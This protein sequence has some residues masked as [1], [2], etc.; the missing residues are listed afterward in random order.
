MTPNISQHSRSCQSA[1]GYTATHDSAS[2]ARLVDVDLQRE[3]HVARRGLHVREHLEAAVGAGGAVGD[4]L[5]LHRRRRVAAVLVALAGRGL[6]VD[7][8]DERQVVAARAR[9]ARPRRPVATS[10]GGCA[11]PGRRSVGSCSS[12]ASPSSAS[13][14]SSSSAWRSSS[15]CGS[16]APRPRALLDLGASAAVSSTAAS[17]VGVSPSDSGSVP[18][19]SVNDDRLPAPALLELVVA[20]ALVLDALLEQHD[21][22]DAAPRAAAGSRARRRRRG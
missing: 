13:S 18:V 8:R 2:M 1:P 3:P 20:D 4:L 22:L 7:G 19:T 10:R 16:G 5:R 17:A 6:P 14:R 21:A 11:R 12:T 9:L 15:A